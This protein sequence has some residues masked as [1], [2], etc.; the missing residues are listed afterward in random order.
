[1][2]I[3]GPTGLALD[4]DGTLYA[5]DAIGNR[6]VAIDQALTR[7]TSAGQGRTITKGGLLN[8]PLAL[9]RA[10]GGH[11]LTTNG[12]NGQVVEI[13]TKTQRQVGAQRFNTDK[14][15]SPPDSGD[16]FGITETPDRKGFYYVEDDVNT[17]QLAE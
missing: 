3:I 8:R 11:L 2:F 7:T 17:L 9:V 4:A 12:L 14:A 13:N 1:M 5:S 16:L 6:I 15:Q 10:T